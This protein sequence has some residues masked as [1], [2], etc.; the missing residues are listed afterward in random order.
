MT[1]PRLGSRVA[2]LPLRPFSVAAAALGLVLACG[3]ATRAASPSLGGA[4]PYGAQRGTE[5]EVTFSGGQLADAQEI[6]FYGPG[7]AV[8]HL[9]PA[10]DAA[11]KARLQIAAD[12]R[13]GAHPF[14]IRTATGITNLRTFS[15][16][17]L[18]EQAETEPNSDFAAP[19]AVP[20]DVC[21]NG[22]V[23]NEDVDYFLVEAGAGQR[24]TAEIEGIRLGNFFF[25]PYVA[26]LDA[27]RFELSSSDD[28][29]L[30]WQDGVASIIAPAAG[31]YL[32]QVRDSAY[33]GNGACIYRLH[34]GRFPRPRAVLPAGGRP[35]E[36]LEV[37]W[38]GDV[39]GER[40]ETLTLP[41]EASSDFVLLA[42][43]EA[44]ISPSG[45]VFRLGSLEGT[46]EVE[47]NS[48]LA[49]ATPTPVPRAL[50]GVIAEP[51]DVDWFKFS[52]TKGQVFDI[53]VLA[54][55]IRSPLD[56]VLTIHRADGA[57]LAGADDS[58]GPDSYLRFSVP[59]D[60]DFFVQVQDHLQGGGVDYAY[61]VELSPVTPQ[62]TLGLPE[63]YQFV[64]VTVPVPRGNR[65]CFLVSASRA[66]F[67]GDLAV[68]FQGLPAGVTVETV[69]MAANQSQIP[70]LISAAADAP[71]AGSLVDVVGRTTDPALQVTGRLVQTT[72]MVRGQN[73][74]HVWDV[75]T[76]RMATAVTSEAPVAIEIVQ[77]KV[78]LVQSGTMELKVIAHRQEGYTA[79]IPIRMLYNPSG[80]GSSGSAVIPEGANEGVIP[81]NAD[82]GAEVRAW[83]IAVYAEA[84]VPGGT[85]T[86]SSQL[87]NLEIA[88]PLFTLGFQAAAVEKGQATE[89][90][91]TINKN[92]D[93]EGNARIELLGLPNEVTATP[94]EFA[95]NAAEVVFPVNTTANSPVG[96]HPTLLCRAV[97][98]ANG[99]PIT[100]V[101]GSGELRIDEPLPPKPMDAAAAPPP[102]PEPQATPAPEKRLTHLE[103]LRLERKQR[104]EAEARTRE[105]A[106]TAPPAEPA[107]PAAGQ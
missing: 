89:V 43:D 81:L 62:L 76:Q 31:K 21:L 57:G 8:T 70:V 23:E 40:A 93:F 78:P 37:R 85:I 65:N 46:L 49:Q 22:V 99:E 12:C 97:V 83:P 74:I 2:S 28:S 25:D 24:I 11:C 45:N 1:T 107:P 66:D 59:E 51:G 80:V 38:L 87:A 7:I 20:L 61:R 54:R 4:S 73:N 88:P 105:A 94:L 15:V 52:A 3:S 16:G 53:R 101:Q 92:R 71:V 95:T 98:M 102:T 75:S 106:E 13:L 68:E 48:T 47:P 44:G 56:S 91:V 35:G 9:E 79:A 55:A 58:G 32:I 33:G 50:H 17:A 41:A 64:D 27:Q 69:P 6:L 19:Q 36:T 104:K 39:A 30:V 26:I 82:G 14:R 67:G 60:G 84:P 5:L 18:P 29:A 34:L 77:P 103:K 90:V 72:S 86:V 96:K 100:Y 10:G 63:R 42:R